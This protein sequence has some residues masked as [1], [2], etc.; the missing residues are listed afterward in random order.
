MSTAACCGACLVVWLIVFCL[1]ALGK[2]KTMMPPRQCNKAGSEE[3]SKS[4]HD[5]VKVQIYLP[6]GSLLSTIQIKISR[7][8]SVCMLA[9]RLLDQLPHFKNDLANHIVQKSGTTAAHCIIIDFGNGRSTFH[10]IPCSTYSDP[11]TI[12][13][14]RAYVRLFMVK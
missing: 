7:N 9:D 10:N 1:K 4:C 11:V 3:A 14:S 12:V 8:E 5:E 13:K 6:G 2:V